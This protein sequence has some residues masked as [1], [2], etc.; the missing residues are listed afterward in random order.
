MLIFDKSVLQALSLDESVW[1]EQFFLINITPLFYVEVLA[2]LEKEV[3]K[4]KTPEQVVG[5]LAKKTPVAGTFFNIHHHTLVVNDLLGHAV[6]MKRRP[7]IKG[8]QPQIS[9]DG[10]VGFFFEES[11]ED[12]A[13]KRWSKREFLEIERDIAKQWRQV[14]SGLTF[15]TFMGIVKNT[16]PPE[17][18]FSNLEQIKAFVDEFIKRS[19]K[20][21]LDLLLLMLDIPSNLQGD[22]IDRWEKM[23]QPTLKNFAPYAA[24]VLS[25]DMFF[26]LALNSSF[27]SQD[28]PSNKID[29]SYLYYLPF[30]M[31]FVSRD[32]L[33][34]RVAPLFMEG[35]QVFAYG[36]D[37]KT[38][39]RELDDYF[40]RFQKE[41][42]EKGV[43][44][45]ASYPPEEIETYIGKLWESSMGTKWKKH[46]SEKKMGAPV[47]QD[48]ELL[49]TLKE[50]KEYSRPIKGAGISS[51]DADRVTFTRRMYVQKG[52]WRILPK[53]IED[54]ADS[55]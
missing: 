33:H 49:K 45:F 4:G 22:I 12:K 44:S 46:R 17:K 53:G 36:D 43:M 7:F 39:L 40:S 14:L 55:S 26:Y 30:C 50:Y 32:K 20:P 2:D 15:E 3:Q 52:K 51:D 23:S 27:I 41:I 18:H 25:V 54:K 47:P 8:G 13:F 29:I 9:S 21:V 10:K 35:E 5:E 24:Y 34:R 42:E 31:V 38:G 28:R 11:P 19:D 37:M 1:L 48:K 6:E 16:V